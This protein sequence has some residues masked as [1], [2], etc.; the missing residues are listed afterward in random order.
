MQVKSIIT[1]YKHQIQ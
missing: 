1:K